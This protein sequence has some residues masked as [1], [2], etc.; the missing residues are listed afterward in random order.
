MTDATQAL[1]EQITSARAEQRQL[2]IVGG[3]SKAFIG[4]A[5]TEGE[6]LEVGRHSGIVSYQPVE[7]VLTA[8][9]G[10][11]LA[12]IEAAL[13]EQ[14]QMLAFEPPHFGGGAT[15]GGTLACNQ[16]GPARPWSGSVRDM[17]LGLRLI[18][19]RG[20]HLRFGGQ[21]IKNVA[22]YDVSRLQAGA[23][24]T[25]GV[26]TEVSLKVMPTPAVTLT[27][28]Q[29]MP[30]DQAIAQMNR[31]SGLPKPLNG[32]FWHDG[33][34]YLRLAGAE[35]AV[36][37]T[38]QQWGGERLNDADTL[39]QQLNN[40][41]L[42]FFNA[43]RPL[44]RFSVNSTAPHWQSEQN[45]LLDWGGSQRWLSGEGDPAVL[46]EQAN[47]AG[48]QVSLFRGGD[49]QGEV[50]P[51]LAPPLQKLHQRLKDAMDP[52]GIFNKGRLY[53]WM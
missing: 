44:W 9:A 30:A 37:G 19:G 33:K 31:Y 20:E 35:S 40:H 5:T 21:V 34:L 38:A 4:R 36:N 27:L 12:E 22:G 24:G 13:A 3:N 43:D 53:G 26:I 6:P 52:D 25:L 28:V 18:N 8:R 39:W 17:V 10:T 16:S 2:R 32:A 41:Q 48:G 15:I 1:I 11:P 45:W 7:L 46:A 51:A 50:S 23:L 49:R 47:A 14:G 29:E 42:D